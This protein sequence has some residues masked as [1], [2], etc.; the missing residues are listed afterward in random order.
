MI[1]P[2]FPSVPPTKRDIRVHIPS[3]EAHGLLE[4]KNS[5]TSKTR[6][7]VFPQEILKRIEYINNVLNL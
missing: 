4:H 2:S 6:A 7:F 3:A 1:L 5:Q